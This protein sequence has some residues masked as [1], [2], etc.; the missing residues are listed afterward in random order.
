MAELCLTK[1]Q[2]SYD[3][4]KLR[5]HF[6]KGGVL[7]VGSLKQLINEA[8][9]LLRK[10]PNVIDISSPSLVFGD[11]HGQYFDFLTELNDKEWEE[12]T[13]KTVFL[14]DYV[15]RGEY[16]CEILITL[17]CMKC[18]DPT[19]VILLRGNHE[20]KSMTYRFG[21]R[22][23]V[24][25]KYSEAVYE[26]F[27]DLFNTI[28]LAA[29]LNSSMGKFL[30]CHGGIS[31]KLNTVDDILAIDRFQEPP[32]TGLFCDLLWSDP[33]NEEFFACNPDALNQWENI[34]FLPN[35]SRNCSYIYGY[36]AISSFI[37]NTTIRGVI[38]GH[39]CVGNGIELHSFGDPDLESPLAFTI[40]SAPNYSDR[41][42]GAGMMISDEG[43]NVRTYSGSSLQDEYSPVLV[44]G[45]SYGLQMFM[46]ELSACWDDFL[47]YTYDNYDPADELP[48]AFTV[49]DI[50]ESLS[51]Y[52]EKDVMG[53]TSA[54]NDERVSKPEVHCEE[55]IACYSEPVKVS[56]KKR[57]PMGK[58]KRVTPMISSSTVQKPTTSEKLRFTSLAAS[59]V[60]ERPT[61]YEMKKKKI[62]EESAP[63]SIDELRKKWEELKEKR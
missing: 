6:M 56:T 46:K 42:R 7:E 49:S 4:T 60:T 41:N 51:K 30:L 35:N 26:Q 34:Q 62:R 23:E 21:F 12:H 15:D 10:E 14:G 1:E 2:G 55:A 29:I 8:M 20:S 53:T 52:K 61:T 50:V 5:Q 3:L 59:I 25:W 57:L 39:Q 17:L 13:H 11:F 27:C 54:V 47:Y 16:S 18:N 43:I 33:T 19:N 32:H 24:I 38:R 28:P 37:D 48:L 63:L 45:I 31:P 40:F 44:N 58:K 36:R 22:T 9:D